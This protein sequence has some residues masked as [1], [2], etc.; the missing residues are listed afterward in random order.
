MLFL[1][2]ILNINMYFLYLLSSWAHPISY[3]FIVPRFRG[4]LLEFC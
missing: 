4:W 3:G 2:N 1:L